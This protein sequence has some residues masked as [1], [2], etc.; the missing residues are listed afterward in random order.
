[1]IS[2]WELLEKSQP[3]AMKILANAVV[4]DRVAHA[5]IF[6]GTK[7]TGKKA[8]SLLFAKS[9]L[10]IERTS[11][12]PCNQCRN[13]KRIES[14]NHP[15]VHYV[16]PDG[17]S[18]KKE[19]ILSLK[20]EFTKTGLESNKKIYI[21][22][23][24]DRMTARAANSLLKFLEEPVGKETVAIL[25]TEQT[26]RLL[27]TIVSR[28]QMIA[29]TPLAPEILARKLVSEGTSESSARLAAQLTNSIEEARELCSDEWFAQARQLVLQLDEMLR[30][31]DKANQLFVFIPSEWMPHFSDKQRMLIG[32]DLL[33]LIYRDLLY[34]Q[35]G[36][37][38]Q[39]VYIDLLETRKSIALKVSQ[40]RLT[41]QMTVVLETKGRLT[42]NVNLQ[43]LMEQLVLNLQ[44]GLE[45][46]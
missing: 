17:N 37:L 43:L 21:V 36:N 20:E 5:Y 6:E 29:F 46:V 45:L 42:T 22:E 9:L 19:Q 4:R 1:M 27:D 25:L 11:Y 41:K 44:E 16:E 35:L 24:V 39:V 2:T 3:V 32:L 34:I 12:L 33:L 38:D 26:H 10:C 8:A 23:H 15:D 28:C 18:I 31:S 13:C 40:K 30:N 7:G 14:G